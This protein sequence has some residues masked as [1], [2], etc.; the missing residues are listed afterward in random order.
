MIN[1]LRLDG[2]KLDAEVQEAILT[3]TV[4]ETVEGASTISLTINDDKRTLVRSGLF[5]DRVTAQVDALSFELV[6][7][8]KNGMALDIDFEDLAVA[9]YR[10]RTTPLKVAGGTMTRKDFIRRLAAEEPWVK[11]VS[12]PWIGNER[13]MVEMARGKVDASAT[14]APEDSWVAMGRLAA[15]VAWRRYVRRGELWFVSESFLFLGEPVAVLKEGVGPVISLDWDFDIGK[16]VAE[17]TATVHAD[18][19]SLL[20]GSVVEVTGEGP[21][22]GKWLVTEVERSLFL[23]EA[24]VTLKKPEPSLPEPTPPPPGAGAS[25]P[26][27]A[28]SA[29]GTPTAPGSSP[30]ARSAGGGVFVSTGPDKDG[31]VWPARGTVSSEFGQ[32]SGRLH[33]GLDISCSVGTAVVAAKAGVVNAILSDP[34]G[35]GSYIVI[36]H[37]PHIYT[38]YAHMS[39]IR[40]ARGQIVRAG[41]VIGKSGGARGAPGAGNSRG[42][43]LHFEIRPNDHPQDPRRFLPR[44]SVLGAVAGLFQ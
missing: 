27:G 30:A 5:N 25:G 17:M 20:P 39:S 18:R 41:E 22:D 4:K 12:P 13:T 3:A 21:A 1:Q 37:D 16:P 43:H 2:A 40:C 6:A 28:T 11:F 7:V 24:K 23:T 42:P 35:Y 34:D 15:E 31:W 36:R 14:E 10:R 44:A 19:W 8:R 38:R 33:A 26:E 32:R 29:A 9:A